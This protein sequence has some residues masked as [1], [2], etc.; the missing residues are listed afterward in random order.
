MSGRRGTL[1]QKELTMTGDGERG[2][3]G[4]VVYID[5]SEIREGRAD[6]LRA[7][8]SKLVDFVDAH[9]P[10]LI[11]YAFHVDEKA[12]EMTVIAVH[13]DSASLELHVEVAGGEFRKLAHLVT[14]REIRI[15]GRPSDRALA[16]LQ[17]KAE[18]LGEGVTVR[19]HEPDAGFAH[20][21]PTPA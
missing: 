20:C 2:H 17:Q 16:L 9:E 3:T 10:Q 6:E 15:Y 18:M 11:A 12:G 13:P 5:R 8:V 21:L 14:L 19:V 7:G 1:L 4:A